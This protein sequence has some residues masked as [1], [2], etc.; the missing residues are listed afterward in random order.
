VVLLK[1]RTLEAITVK[2]NNEEVAHKNRNTNDERT[3][4]LRYRRRHIVQVE[5]SPTFKNG[6]FSF[7]ESSSKRI[8]GC[9]NNHPDFGYRASSVFDVVAIDVWSRRLQ[10]DFSMSMP[11]SMT[12]EAPMVPPTSSPFVSEMDAPTAEPPSFMETDE[13]NNDAVRRIGL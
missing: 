9:P 2:M 13:A 1:D 7:I 5:D 8:A 10:S 12:T 11:T 4:P 3:K 6:A